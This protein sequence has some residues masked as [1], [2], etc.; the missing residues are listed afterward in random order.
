[1]KRRFLKGRK[2]TKNYKMENDI[3]K[4]T[5]FQFYNK[6]YDELLKRKRIDADKCEREDAFMSIIFDIENGKSDLQSFKDMFK[7]VHKVDLSD[8]TFKSA[9]ALVAG[10]RMEVDLHGNNYRKNDY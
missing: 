1:M 2:Y 8:E 3:M 5:D 10:F 4:A 9:Y 6:L 7:A